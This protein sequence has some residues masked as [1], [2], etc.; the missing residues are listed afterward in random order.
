MAPLLNP[1]EMANTDTAA[2]AARCGARTRRASRPLVGPEAVRERPAAAWTRRCS[3]WRASRS[4]TRR[5]IP[6]AASTTPT[7]KGAPG[8]PPTEAR[9]LALFDDPA[10]GNCAGVPSRSPRTGRAA[11][12]VH[13]LPVRGA[14]R[15]A[16]RA[17]CASARAGTSRDLGLCGPVR[18]DLAHATQYCG[19]FRTPSLR[20]VATR[21]RLLSQRPLSPLDDVLALLRLPRRPAARR[22]TRRGRREAS[23]AFDD[24]PAADTGNVDV[25]DPPFGRRGGDPGALGA[26]DRRDIIAFLRTLTDGWYVPR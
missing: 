17:D 7:S 6:T 25:T 4:R 22:S 21:L 3:P 12:G 20:N 26:E 10:Q 23:G 11:A 1:V 18:T 2:L 15:A 9:G 24:L 5:S 14:R 16:Q 13:R 19:M 8:S